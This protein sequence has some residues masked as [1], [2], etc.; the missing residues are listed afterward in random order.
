MAIKKKNKQ[1]EKAMKAMKAFI[2]EIPNL[3]DYELRNLIGE[4]ADELKKREAKRAEM[5]NSIEDMCKYMI[6]E[7]EMTYTFYYEA[8]MP[9][10]QLMAENDYI[11]DEGYDHICQ[12]LGEKGTRAVLCESKTFLIKKYPQEKGSCFDVEM[13]ERVDVL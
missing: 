2:D 13:I 1:E 12:Q 6:R 9:K 3:Y 11:T 7:K 10:E 4:I 5:I 8:M